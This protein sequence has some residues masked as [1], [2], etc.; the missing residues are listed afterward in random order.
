M[1]ADKSIVA[2][3][4][5]NASSI[6]RTGAPF[7]R[8][9]VLVTENSQL[10]DLTAGRSSVRHRILA[11][12]TDASP[13]RLRLPQ[14]A[15]L[16]GHKPGHGLS[17]A[18]EARRGGAYPSKSCGRAGAAA[19]VVGS[20]ATL[21]V[22]LRRRERAALHNSRRFAGVHIVDRKATARA[23]RRAIMGRCQTGP[24]TQMPETPF[25][26]GPRCGGSNRS[27]ARR[28]A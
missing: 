9:I 24:L 14:G 7:P 6:S 23:I 19:L 22:S 5:E 26:G 12:L 17:R 15:A 13:T 4:I 10:V 18:G 2:T 16:C 3:E 11:P 21:P 25:L 1:F 8:T 28:S 20:A 27:W